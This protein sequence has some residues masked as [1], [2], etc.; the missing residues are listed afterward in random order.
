[1]DIY[2]RAINPYQY[3]L[4]DM[5]WEEE[6]TKSS[7]TRTLHYNYHLFKYL[8]NIKNKSCLDIGCGTGQ[9]LDEFKKRGA[10]KAQGFEPSIKNIKIAKALYP[11]LKITR[12]TLQEFKIK[13]QF[14]IITC[15]MVLVHIP[16]LKQAFEKFKSLLNENGELY[17]IVEN[18]S[19]FEKPRHGYEFNIK[20]LNKKEAVIAVK[21]RY[22][23]T[24]DVIR[25]IEVY[26]KVAKKTGLVLEKEVK[27][28]FTK[29]LIKAAPR[30]KSAKN[31]IINHLLIYRK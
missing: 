7:P 23:F 8:K 31:V 11:D 13:D 29:N 17:L 18:F 15:I 12:S 25:K 26:K 24:A 1:M 5:Q 16:N 3:D 28:K 27:L 6:G 14:D 21:R 30:Y 4:S 19:Y 2:K 22:G 20:E 9:L 10:K